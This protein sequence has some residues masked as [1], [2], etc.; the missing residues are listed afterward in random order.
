[1]RLG[2]TKLVWILFA[3]PLVIGLMKNGTDE[4]LIS[5]AVRNKAKGSSPA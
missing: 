4:S 2:V 5:S 1:M 3:T